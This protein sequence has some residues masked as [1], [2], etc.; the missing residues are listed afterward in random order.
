MSQAR[1]M[2]SPCRYFSFMSRKKEDSSEE[3]V[4]GRCV[5]LFT[6]MEISEEQRKQA[7]SNARRAKQGKNKSKYIFAT[8]MS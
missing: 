7:I 5:L 4:R 1:I 3:V 6:G 8:F 2:S